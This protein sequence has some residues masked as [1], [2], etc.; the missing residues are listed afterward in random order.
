MGLQEFTIV[1]ISKPES[2]LD[3]AAAIKADKVQ[4]AIC[5]V[6][7]TR[8]TGICIIVYGH[9]ETK[10]VNC[11]PHTW[12]LFPARNQPITA[13]SGVSPILVSAAYNY[14]GSDSVITQQGVQ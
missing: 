11:L 4:V 13:I 12:F 7:S 14:F 10:S 8:R 9:F 1:F 3:V 5:G 2:M 6:T